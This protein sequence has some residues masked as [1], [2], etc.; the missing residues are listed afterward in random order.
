LL[1]EVIARN[2]EDLPCSFAFGRLRGCPLLLFE[3][4]TERLLVLLLPLALNTFE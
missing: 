2:S 4:G 3:T 1:E